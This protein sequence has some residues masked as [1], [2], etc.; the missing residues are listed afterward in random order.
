MRNQQ[1]I[2]RSRLMPVMHEC[3]IDGVTAPPQSR[4]T[5]R[6]RS[7]KRQ[8]TD[9]LY[10]KALLQNESYQKQMDA[11]PYI[12]QLREL[13]NSVP[14]VRSSSSSS[15]TTDET[16]PVAPPPPAATTT[17][18]IRLRD[19]AKYDTAERA[20][21]EK[22]TQAKHD[23]ALP[24]VPTVHLSAINPQDVA[25]LEDLRLLEHRTPLLV[26]MPLLGVEA[27]ILH[28]V[29]KLRSLPGALYVSSAARERIATQFERIKMRP[30]TGVYYYFSGVR[31]E[32]ICIYTDTD[33]P[34][35][36]RNVVQGIDSDQI[37]TA[38]HTL[39]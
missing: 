6:Q 9:E 10:V 8:A 39:Y 37:Y 2:R 25:S 7:A 27:A 38:I 5:I 23:T 3:V 1:V 33:L 16:T 18:P 17:A 4:L 28:H 11:S 22:T 26:S 31:T 36:I 14:A 29:D 34:M 21:A 19:L 30:F 12:E 15:S 24:I 35:W 32:A 20:A 13:A